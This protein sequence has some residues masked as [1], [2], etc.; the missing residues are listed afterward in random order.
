MRLKTVN[1]PL[2]L[3]TIQSSC[4]NQKAKPRRLPHHSYN[5]PLK[6]VIFSDIYISVCLDGI[7]MRNHNKKQVKVRRSWGDLDPK[8]KVHKDKSKYDRAQT[9]K[10]IE[11]E[12][13]NVFD[14]EEFDDVFGDDE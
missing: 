1:L 10:E 11:S 4:R 8:T 13:D 7:F 9:K 2:S 3:K 5:S 14:V 6:S 12:L